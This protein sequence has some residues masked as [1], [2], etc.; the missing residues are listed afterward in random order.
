FS[1][2]PTPGTPEYEERLPGVRRQLDAFTHVVDYYYRKA[3]ITMPQPATLDNRRDWWDGEV[4]PDATTTVDSS[5]NDRVLHQILLHL[6]CDDR[7]VFH[8]N[9]IRTL[10]SQQQ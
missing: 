9:D 5:E 4:P 6:D 10:L 8:R 7:D 1:T 2:G 3:G